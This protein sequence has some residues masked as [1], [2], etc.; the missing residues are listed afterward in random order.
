[1]T[2]DQSLKSHVSTSISPEQEE[3]MGITEG[4]LSYTLTKEWHGLKHFVVE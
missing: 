2:A 1:M 4:V 3:I